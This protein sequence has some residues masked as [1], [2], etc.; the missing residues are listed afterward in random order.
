MMRKKTAMMLDSRYTTLIENAY[1]YCNPPET[2][3]EKQKERNPVYEY[4]RKLLYKDL[5]RVTIEKV[6]HWPAAG[7]ICSTEL[8]HLQLYVIKCFWLGEG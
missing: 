5:S 8:E 4:V 1:Y 3:A 7:A 6:N 2:K